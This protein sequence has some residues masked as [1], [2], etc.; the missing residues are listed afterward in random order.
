M[1]QLFQHASTI[2]SILISFGFFV[3]PSLTEWQRPDDQ[4]ILCATRRCVARRFLMPLHQAQRID[5]ED[6]T[7]A[8]RLGSGLALWFTLK[9]SSWETLKPRVSWKLTWNSMYLHDLIYASRGFKGWF[10]EEW[11]NEFP[12]V[13]IYRFI[14]LCIII[15]YHQ[16]QT[17]QQVILCAPTPW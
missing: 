17:H 13:P 2:S 1:F 6:L 3:W 7:V 15:D 16:T 11:G 4:F 12:I 5:H 9:V 14:P 8:R 10:L